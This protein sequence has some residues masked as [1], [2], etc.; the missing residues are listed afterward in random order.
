MR[1]ISERLGIQKGGK[2]RGCNVEYVETGWRVWVR[3]GSDTAY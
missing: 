2:L 1:V 3:S